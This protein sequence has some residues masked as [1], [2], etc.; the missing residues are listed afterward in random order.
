MI[1]PCLTSPQRKQP[2]KSK[3][4]P[5]LLEDKLEGLRRRNANLEAARSGHPKRGVSS[6]ASTATAPRR[7][8]RGGTAPLDPAAMEDLPSLT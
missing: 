4:N 3:D 5:D 7:S 6:V 1:H 8:G 2:L